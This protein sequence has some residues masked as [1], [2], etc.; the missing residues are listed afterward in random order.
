M[1][2]S[3]CIPCF[4]QVEYLAKCMDS[5]V[6]QTYLNYEV[7]I[8]DDSITDGVRNYIIDLEKVF[9]GKL[10]YFRN[11]PSK[12]T[13]GNW[14]QAMDMATG[15]FI[16]LLHHDDY[17]ASPD[18]L[19]NIMDAANTYPDTNVFIGEV[20]SHNI[21]EKSLTKHVVVD[22]YLNDLHSN[23]SK[24]LFANLLGPPSIVFLRKSALIYF[25]VKL[26]W[27]V[28]MEYYYRLFKANSNWMFVRKPFVVSVNNADH[29]VT[30]ECYS[31][32]EVEVFEYTYLYN[33]VISGFIPSIS[34]LCLIRRLFLKYGLFSFQEVLSLCK[35][36][37]IPWFYKPLIKILRIEYALKAK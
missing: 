31:N 37:K 1:K 5:I 30:N 10:F 25:N 24:I 11:S 27:L 12:G 32:P 21:S 36:E 23:P 20:L 29:N 8:S 2:I 34:F 19:K 13:P 6:S 35:T 28:D 33:R 22:E 17:Y 14:N 16:H 9:N 18:S 26:K 15:D 7:I 3:I 4:E